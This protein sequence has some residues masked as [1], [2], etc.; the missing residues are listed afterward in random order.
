MYKGKKVVHI[1]AS[2]NGVIGKDNKMIW[3]VPEDFKFFREKT[4]GNVLLM[5]GNTVKSLPKPLEKRIVL[6]V[7][8]IAAMN[9]TL[10][11]QNVSDVDVLE[12]CLNDAVR[13]SD[14]LNTDT[15]FIAGGGM[16]YETTMDIVDEIYR[17]EVYRTDGQ[18]FS[19]DTFYSIGSEMLVLSETGILESKN[20]D[21]AYQIQHFVRGSVC[22]E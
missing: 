9:Y 2:G 5:G 12:C 7:S 8:S 4:I 20:K 1:V 16:L 11:F 13:K 22:K 17:T 19:G 21:Y 15:I 3:H 6:E 10:P 14:L 18:K